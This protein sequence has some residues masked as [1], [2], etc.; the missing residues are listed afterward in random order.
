MD[1]PAGDALTERG[2][3]NGVQDERVPAVV[4][5]LA[6]YEAPARPSAGGGDQRGRLADDAARGLVAFA[7][8]RDAEY[9]AVKH[10]R[11]FGRTGR[12]E[13]TSQ[14]CS[15]C[16]IKDGPK[17]LSVREW[18]CQACRTARDRD[19]NAARNIMAAGRADRLN[20]SWSAGKTGP[21]A[22]QRVEAGSRQKGQT[23]QA[24]IL[25]L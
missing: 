4:D 22:A 21:V 25:V 15:A 11:P 19:V 7:V 2:V 1:E 12:F 9:K 14:V 8:R 6:R 23:T 10:G 17:P 18:T 5:Q 13:P 3:V 16:G 24:G 20:A